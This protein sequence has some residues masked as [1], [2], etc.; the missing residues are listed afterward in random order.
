[1]RAFSVVVTLCTLVAAFG[2][3]ESTTP[4]APTGG[5]AEVPVPGTDVDLGTPAPPPA[6]Q[7]EPPVEDLPPPPEPAPA[8]AKADVSVEIR[9]WQ[10]VEQLIA[11]HKGKVVVVDLWST[12]CPPC[13]AEFPGLVKL[14]R[15]R[16]DQV[17][18][19]SVSTDY[20]QGRKPV[21]SFLPDVKQFL[22]E[23][24][25]TFTNI[26][27][28]QDSDA[29]FNQLKLGSI[30]AVYVYD[31]EGKLAKRF[32]EPEGDEEHTYARDI[33]PFVEGLLAGG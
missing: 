13:R 3:S 27:C 1:M 6:G 21:E 24:G 33:R 29:L 14:H 17:A 20:Y 23:Q 15:E 22:S 30:P 8:A 31:R 19:I 12:G 25:A 9:D 28:S 26:L 32:A 11:S 4:P 5:G 2:C 10:A 7:S 16:G 18:C